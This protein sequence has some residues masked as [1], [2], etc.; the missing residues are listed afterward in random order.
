MT[1]VKLKDKVSDHSGLDLRVVAHSN[2]Q[3]IE[4]LVIVQLDINPLLVWFLSS[5]LAS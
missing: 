5:N 4:V 1:P 2:V 3:W